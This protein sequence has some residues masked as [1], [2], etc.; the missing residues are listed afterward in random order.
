[1][2][3]TAAACD[4]QPSKQPA[5][6]AL[7]QQSQEPTLQYHQCGCLGPLN[8]E[9]TCNCYDSRGLTCNV[10]DDKM[11]LLHLLHMCFPVAIEAG[12]ACVKQS[13]RH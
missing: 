9:A 13:L 3:H 11:L 10:N 5:G 7:T 4:D 8:H 12:F 6:E 2:H 1:M